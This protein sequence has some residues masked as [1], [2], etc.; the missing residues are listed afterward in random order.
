[1]K[2]EPRV[3][4]P[5]QDDTQPALEPAGWW[6][7]TQS[8]GPGGWETVNQEWF[9]SFRAWKEIYGVFPEEHRRQVDSLVMWTTKHWYFRSPW[10]GLSVQDLVSLAWRRLEAERRAQGRY[11]PPAGHMGAA[12]MAHTQKLWPPH[13][14]AVLA[15]SAEELEAECALY[16]L[17]T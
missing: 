16:S 1:M 9:H 8:G 15:L 4:H 6:C 12:D 14:A 17:G 13:V 10:A 2:L 3:G 5:D 11:V 7:L